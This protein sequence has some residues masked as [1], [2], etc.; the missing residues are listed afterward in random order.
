MCVFARKRDSDCFSRKLVQSTSGYLNLDQRA[1]GHINW[2]WHQTYRMACL[3]YS[4]DNPLN[5]E[6][7]PICYLLALLAHHFLHV[8]RIRVNLEVT[9]VIFLVLIVIFCMFVTICST[10]L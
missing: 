1:V 2:V 9:E 5:P 8:S 7:N 3:Q 10:T 4:Y 6:L